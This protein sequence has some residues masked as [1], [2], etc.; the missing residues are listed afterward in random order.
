VAESGPR[1]PSSCTGDALGRAISGVRVGNEL[2]A[3]SAR[4]R[5]AVILSFEQ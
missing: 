2:Q 3:P 5:I 1:G 4:L